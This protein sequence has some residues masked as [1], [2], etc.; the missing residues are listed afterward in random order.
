MSAMTDIVWPKKSREIQNQHMD[1]TVWNSV[2]FRDTDIVIA[3]LSQ[4]RHNLVPANRRAAA[5][6]RG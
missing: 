1:S 3:T 5:L 4:V 2:N 6:Q